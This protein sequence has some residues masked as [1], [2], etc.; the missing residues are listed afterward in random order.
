[1]KRFTLLITL[2]IG[3]SALSMSSY[4]QSNATPK[5]QARAQAR[6]AKQAAAKEANEEA[7]QKAEQAIAEKDWV[8][9]ANTVYGP[10]GNSYVVSGMTNFIQFDGNTVYLQLAFNDVVS[11]PNGLGGI[12]LEGTPSSMQKTTTKNG[13]IVYEFDVNGLTLNAD[14]QII[15]NAGNN[16]ATGTVYPDFSSNNLTFSGYLVPTSESGIYRSGFVTP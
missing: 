4:A 12:T 7:F 3:L 11:G 5:Q 1:M 16:Y 15:V 6:A 9:T 10:D 14:V 2:V 13:G 8:L